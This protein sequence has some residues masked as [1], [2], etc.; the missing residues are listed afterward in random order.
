MP[1]TVHR[2][3]KLRKVWETCDFRYLCSGSCQARH[4]AETGSIDKAGEFCE[5][6][7]KGIVEGLIASIDTKVPI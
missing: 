1:Q 2:S 5:Y 4:F 6:E 3:V 7:K